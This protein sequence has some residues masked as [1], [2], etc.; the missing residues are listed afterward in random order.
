MDNHVG[1]QT[2]PGL[3]GLLICTLCGFAMGLIIG[4]NL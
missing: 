4:I 1:Q 3:L 2:K